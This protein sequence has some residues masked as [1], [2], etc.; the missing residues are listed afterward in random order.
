MQQNKNNYTAPQTDVFV[1]NGERLMDNPL[2]GSST[3]AG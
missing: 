2:A 1:V 3:H